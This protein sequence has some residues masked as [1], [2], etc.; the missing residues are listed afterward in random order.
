MEFNYQIK[1]IKD[2][3]PMPDEFGNYV[4][5]YQEPRFV[6][7]D[8][9]SITRSEFYNAAQSGMKPEIVFTINR[10]EYH[11]EHT[12]EFGGVL[13]TVIRTYESNPKSGTAVDETLELVC[14]RKINNG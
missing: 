4:A 9:R 5:M 2:I 13:Y 1:L 14:E 6:Y 7:A 3:C 10:F 11:D 8:K 12:V